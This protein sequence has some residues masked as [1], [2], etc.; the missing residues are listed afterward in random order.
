MYGDGIAERTLGLWLKGQRRDAITLATKCG[1][2]PDKVAEKFPPWGYLTRV[3]RRILSPIGFDQTPRRG[4]TAELVQRSVEQSLQLL[5]T[6]YLDILFIHDP[7]PEDLPLLPKL[8]N[9]LASLKQA[10][11]VRCVGVAGDARVCINAQNEV[12][13]VFDVLQV[14]DS[15]GHFEADLLTAAGLPLQVTFG[16]LRHALNAER[17]VTNGPAEIVRQAL[18]RNR[19]GVVLVSS[20][21]QGRLGALAA[22]AENL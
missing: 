2:L 1:L 21:N 4:Y 9:V 18:S 12:P 14:K 7:R 13:G 15:I 16:Y 3:A 17:N 19:D 6:D 10:G 8:V 5:G 22:A 11:K 20:R